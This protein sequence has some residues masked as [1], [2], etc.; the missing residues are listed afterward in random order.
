MNN[1]NKLFLLIIFELCGQNKAWALPGQI[2]Q[3]ID[4]LSFIINPHDRRLVT[5]NAR[6]VSY[7]IRNNLRIQQRNELI[8]KHT[9]QKRFSFIE[10]WS[11]RGI[12]TGL[13]GLTVGLWLYY[14]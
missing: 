14:K 8:K 9:I 10:K 1:K 2:G 3:M 11:F 6:V 7:E 12:C 5:E 13:G 4:P